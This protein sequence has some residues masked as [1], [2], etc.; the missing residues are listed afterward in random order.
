[1]A[2]D[3]IYPRRRKSPEQMAIQMAEGRAKDE[4]ERKANAAYRKI[5][6]TLPVHSTPGFAE[7]EAARQQFMEGTLTVEQA[8]SIPGIG[9]QPATQTVFNNPVTE[10]VPF[11]SLWPEATVDNPPGGLT[12]EQTQIWADYGQSGQDYAD[13]PGWAHYADTAAGSQGA[14]SSLTSLGGVLAAGVGVIALMSFLK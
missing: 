11:Q 10:K 7:R 8:Q 3:F 12:P 14:A 13:F 4:A 5:H 6:G 1:M 2:S 9:Y